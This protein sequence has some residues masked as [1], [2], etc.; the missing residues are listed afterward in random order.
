MLVFA[1]A[2]LESA[3]RLGGFHAPDGGQ[4]RRPCRESLRL[5]ADAGASLEA[6]TETG[7]T[8]LH[9]AA[10]S[11][12]LRRPRW[13]PWSDKGAEVNVQETANGADAA[14]V[15]R[16]LR[17]DRRGALAA[18]RRARIRR[19][20]PTSS[21]TRPWPGKTACSSDSV[22]PASPRSS[23]RRLFQTRP[24]TA[25]GRMTRTRTTKPGSEDEEEEER[26]AGRAATRGQTR[27]HRCP[28]TSWWAGR[29][30][31]R[32][33]HYAAREGHHDVVKT[34]LD[35]GADIDQVTGGDLSSRAAHGDPERPL[36]SGH[37][38]ARPGRRPQP[39]RA[40]RA[41]RPLYAAVHL[42]WVPEVLLSAAHRDQAGEAPPTL[43]S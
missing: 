15:R 18:R 5:L 27:S 2:N 14:H 4:P 32:H 1:G 40:T 35:G 24:W 41:P 30:A 8:A 3:T 12:K 39:A 25:P 16:R 38:A 29:A 31:T 43:S 6:T 37:V 19:S 9:Y 26:P 17:P 23:V 7:E 28:T 13:P 36:R 20:R 33:V 21:T 11:G 22:T 34:L 10:W 42:Q